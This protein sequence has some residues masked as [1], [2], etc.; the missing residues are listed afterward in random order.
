MENMENVK[1]A[2]KTGILRKIKALRDSV[3]RR[4]RV[5]VS[6]ALNYSG[7]SSLGKDERYAVIMTLS[8]IRE[9]GV[10]L[11]MHPSKDKFYIESSER[12][13]LVVVD[14]TSITVSN[15]VYSNRGEIGRRCYERIRRMFVEEAEKQRAAMEDEYVKGVQSPLVIVSRDVV[16]WN[17]L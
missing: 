3:M 16:G 15:K 12:G 7:S 4:I 6:R 13:L 10:S 17:M 5:R 11:L 1:K 2:G 14:E 8:L 9:G